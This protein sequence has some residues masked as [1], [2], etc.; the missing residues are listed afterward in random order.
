MPAFFPKA[1]YKTRARIEQA[2]GK[3]KRFKRIA[4]RCEKTAQNYG[5]FVA[6]ALGFILIKSVHTCPCRKLNPYVLMVQSSKHGPTLDAAMILNGPSNGSILSASSAIRGRNRST[7][8]HK[9]ILQKANIPQSIIRF[10]GR[11]QPD[12]IYDRDTEL[13]SFPGSR[14]D[15][16]VDSI[17]QALN[18]VLSSSLWKW[19][20]LGRSP[21]RAGHV[22]SFLLRRAQSFFDADPVAGEQPPDRAAAAGDPS[23]AHCHDDFIQRQIRL[24]TNQRQQP[25][26][27]L[28]QRRDASPNRFGREASSFLPALHPF[29]R[30]TR[31]H[32]KTFSCLAPRRARFNG[33]KHTF[34]QVL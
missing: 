31:A 20:K 23:L 19:I 25:V 3:L 12:E 18:H 27:V 13:F 8:V 2:V 28:L 15:D 11:C 6:L 16:Q 22:G 17:S 34:A 29:D 21:A 33:F 5:S 1:L 26:G 30:R 4:L 24:L 9:I 14:H 7:T 32:L 10:C